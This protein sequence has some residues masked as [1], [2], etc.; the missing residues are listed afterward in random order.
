MLFLNIAIV[1]HSSRDPGV[2]GWP[3]LLFSFLLRLANG[4]SADQQKQIME[5]KES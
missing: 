5:K 4:D 3:L 2:F 1:E